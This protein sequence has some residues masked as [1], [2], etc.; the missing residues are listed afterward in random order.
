MINTIKHDDGDAAIE[1]EHGGAH[2]DPYAALSPRTRRKHKNRDQMRV[3]RQRERETMDCLRTTVERLEEQYKQMQLAHPT[4]PRRPNPPAEDANANGIVTGDEYATLIS[5]KSQAQEENFL[6][7]QAL[8]EKNKHSETLERIVSDLGEPT[9]DELFTMKQEFPSVNGDD[10]LP[11]PIPTSTPTMM[12]PPLRS[13]P[14]S[15]GFTPMTQDAVWRIINDTHHKMTAVEERL[16]GPSSGEEPR[17]ATSGSIT[18][19]TPTEDAT[20]PLSPDSSTV[21]H[22]STNPLPA[23]CGWDVAHCVEQGHVWFAFDKAFPHIQAF[24][25]MERMWENEHKMTTYR[26]ARAAQHQTL[27]IVQEINDDT[28]VFERRL[29]DPSTKRVV[30]TTYLRFRMRTTVGF[31]I[32]L[33]TLCRDDVEAN[34]VWASQTCI[35]T[36]FLP[37]AT[38]INTDLGCRVRI[39]GSTNMDNPRNAHRHV[40]DVIIGL[41]RWE[42][43]TIGPTFTLSNR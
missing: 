30:V 43:L 41:L 36:E 33:A 6:L 9:D 13:P 12:H 29:A 18:V 1:S 24:Y 16:R 14:R 7:K 19:L 4:T 17:S 39:T 31:L 38:D 21:G 32:G 11:P 23:F 42:Y 20:S 2:E 8:Y 28:Y 15:P 34:A 26:D 10:V 37:A 3:A 35:W 27:A 22:K 5:L 25:A 40:A